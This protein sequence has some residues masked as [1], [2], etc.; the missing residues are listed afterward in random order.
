VL[1]FYWKFICSITVIK[2]LLA[3]IVPTLGSKI[4]E[5]AL[6]FLETNYSYLHSR[7][8]ELQKHFVIYFKFR[9]DLDK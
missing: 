5:L 7:T 8:Q 3:K 1:L 4:D 2:L 9:A 6:S